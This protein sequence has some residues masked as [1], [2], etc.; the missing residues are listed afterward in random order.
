MREQRPPRGIVSQGFFGEPYIR[1]YSVNVK[2]S[3]VYNDEPC[4]SDSNGYIKPNSKIVELEDLNSI[5]DG[6]MVSY[7]TETM[8]FPVYSHKPEFRWEIMVFGTII[9]KSQYV[10]IMRERIQRK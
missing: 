5:Y 8:N 10:Q 9:L 7:G 3:C 2:G 1:S 6:I 4:L